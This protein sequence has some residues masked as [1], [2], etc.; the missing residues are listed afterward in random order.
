MVLMGEGHIEESFRELSLIT[1]TCL[2]EIL[3][4]STQFT[5]HIIKQESMPWPVFPIKCV[6][7]S[8]VIGLRIS[9]HLENS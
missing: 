6:F 7:P 4:S 8:G 3:K 1:H 5:P 2:L 9:G